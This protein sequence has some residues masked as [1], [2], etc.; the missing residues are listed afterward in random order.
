[1]RLIHAVRDHNAEH[2]DA[3]IEVVA[4]HTDAEHAAMFVREADVA[5][6]L[7]PAA[8][9]PYL[10]LAILERALVET[11]GHADATALL[12]QLKG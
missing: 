8:A 11:P 12:G 10:D 5:Y 1:M 9:R 7:G 6:S 4:L 3:P 2:A